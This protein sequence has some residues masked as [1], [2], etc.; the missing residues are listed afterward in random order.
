MLSRKINAGLSLL[1]T[2]LLLDHALFNSIRMLS[3]GRVAT[4]FNY[5]PWILTVL[6]AIHAFISIDLAIS[7]HLNGEKCKC[8]NYP[9][10]NAPTIVQRVS[11][12]LLI[13]FTALHIAGAAK[14]M[15]PPA[16]VHAILPPLF[17]AVALAHAAISTSKAFITLGIGSAR[18]VKAADIVI[19]VICVLTLI[20][21]VMGFY[22]YNFAG[23]G[24]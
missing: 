4:S 12:V 9:K 1:T 22:L 3:G 16:V 7:S 5:A 8:K 6:M 11:G 18:F 21:G 20:A 13:L 14:Y 24:K 15:V 17:F 19:K 10:M 23:V 2:F